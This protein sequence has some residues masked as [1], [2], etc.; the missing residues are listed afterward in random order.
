LA[1]G[2]KLTEKDIQ[3]IAMQHQ[4]MQYQAEGLMQQVN[5]VGMS[6]DESK[7]AI[8]SI[9]ELEGMEDG[10]EILVPIGSNTNVRANLVKPDGVIIEIGA[11]ISMEK[12]L[13]DAKVSL[14]KQNKELTQYQQNL[15]ESLNQIISKMKEM[16]AVVQA[17]TQQKQQTQ[18]RQPMQGS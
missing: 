10:H 7:R 1:S 13:E 4:Q 16:E 17:A 8:N 11:G 3:N 12:K 18:T 15:Q 2:K 6:I 5:M 9:N 14:E